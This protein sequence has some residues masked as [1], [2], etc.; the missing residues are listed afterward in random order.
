M[1]F[2]VLIM[3][4][5]HKSQFFQKSWVCDGSPDCSHGEDETKCQV[6]C[7]ESKFKCTSQDGNDT[8]ADY[9]INKKLVCDG[10]KDCPRGEDEKDCP[11]KKPCDKTSNCTQL[12]ILTAYGKD[13]CSCHPGYKLAED[14][15]T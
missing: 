4:M 8:S 9:C 15:I 6:Y 1:C 13:A 10:Q 5:F 11:K 12:C 14:G 3:K 2:T 7:D